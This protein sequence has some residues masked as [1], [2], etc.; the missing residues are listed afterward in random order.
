MAAQFTPSEVTQAGVAFVHQDLGLL[1]HLS[2]SENIALAVGYAK[3]RRLIS[4]ARTERRAQTF[5]EDLGVSSRR[6]G[7][8]AS[9]PRT[10][11]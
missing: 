9:W 3:R 8:W 5:L 2:V 6:T 7:W 11:R 10:R 4:F 1:A